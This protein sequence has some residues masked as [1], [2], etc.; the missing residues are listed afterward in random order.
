MDTDSTEDLYI[1]DI[2]KHETYSPEE[3]EFILGRLNDERLLDQKSKE[4]SSNLCSLEEKNAIL[5]ELNEERLRVQKREE[6]KKKRLENKQIYK[7]GN[8][9]YYKFTGMKRAFYIEAKF[10]ETFSGRPTVVTLYYLTFNELK[11]KDVLIQIRAESEKF[12]ISYDAIRVYF[13]PYALENKR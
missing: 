1:A 12:F 11:K 13:K 2:S 6:M 4:A 7:F 8:K 3:K 10:C 5:N 9:E